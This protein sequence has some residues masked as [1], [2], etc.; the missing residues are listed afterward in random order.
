MSSCA[1]HAL[2]TV[3]N[4]PTPVVLQAMEREILTF[5]TSPRG[6]GNA[7]TFTEWNTSQQCKGINNT[8]QN[9]V[10]SQNLDIVLTHTHTK[11]QT[12]KSLSLTISFIVEKHGRHRVSW[13]ISVNITNIKTYQHHKTLD[14]MM[15]VILMR[16]LAK[17]CITSLQLWDNI[18]QTQVEGHSTK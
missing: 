7:V 6:R 14:M 10:E 17:K 2:Y 13:V 9:M 18:E 5:P 11:S 4:G 1:G 3:L 8:C 16:I 12:P 15:H